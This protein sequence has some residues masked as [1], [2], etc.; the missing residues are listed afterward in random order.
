MFYQSA[1]L[2]ADE[3]IIYPAKARLKKGFNKNFYR[4]FLPAAAAAA[5]AGPMAI[6]AVAEAA[7]M[8]GTANFFLINHSY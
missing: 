3:S 6:L 1:R 5:Q 2:L 4:I 8:A 7:C